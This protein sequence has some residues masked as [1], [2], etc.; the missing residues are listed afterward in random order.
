MRVRRVPA[1]YGCYG[2]LRPGPVSSGRLEGTNEGTEDPDPMTSC[3]SA[4]E[5]LARLGER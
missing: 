4:H 3:L 2:G 5:P 1:E